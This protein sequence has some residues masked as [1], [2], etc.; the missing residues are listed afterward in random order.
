MSFLTPQGGVVFTSADSVVAPGKWL[1]GNLSGLVLDSEPISRDLL[2]SS[3]WMKS[4][5]NLERWAIAIN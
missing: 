1:K 4:I 5:S 3:A 2:S